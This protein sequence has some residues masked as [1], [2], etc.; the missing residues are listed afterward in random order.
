MTVVGVTGH[1][2]LPE[3]AVALVRRR[4]PALLA[5]A[6]AEALV[7]SL[8]DGADQ[9]CARL[10]LNDGYQLRVIVPCEN[11]ES[12]FDESGLAEYR[13]LLDAAE[14]VERLGFPAPSEQAF[15]TAG[16]AV[17]DSADL[18]VAIWDGEPAEGVGGTGDVV[19]YARQSGVRTCVIWPEG[20]S[21]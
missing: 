18:L 10:A 7:G 3:P 13:N 21:R 11:Y 9:L 1:Q 14:S 15:L 6:G 8:A 5:E 16:R 20:L 4:L 17:V 2:G 19:V 12:T